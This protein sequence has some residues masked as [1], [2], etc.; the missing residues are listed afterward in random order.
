MRVEQDVDAACKSGLLTHLKT[1]FL[2]VSS[3]PHEYNLP[4]KSNS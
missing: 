3:R 1:G 4:I 2:H